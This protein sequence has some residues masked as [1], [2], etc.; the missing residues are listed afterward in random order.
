MTCFVSKLLPGCV[1]A[2]IT[3]KCFLKQCTAPTSYTRLTTTALHAT[4][5]SPY[6]HPW[7]RPG[8]AREHQMDDVESSWARAG[9]EVRRH[10]AL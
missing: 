3:S 8:S 6:G 9:G 4:P 5:I 1:A 10:R 2:P 7:R